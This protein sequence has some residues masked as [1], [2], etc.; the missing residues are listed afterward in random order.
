MP[1]ITINSKKT[2]HTVYGA[3]LRN[4]LLFNE[5]LPII[6]NSTLNQ[7]F[8]VAED[9][10]PTGLEKPIVQYFGVGLNGVIQDIGINNLYRTKYRQYQPRWGSALLSF[11]LVMRPIAEDLSIDERAF[12]RMRKLQ[13]FDGI[14]YA[15]YYLR[16]IDL[17][18][19]RSE[20]E[21]RTT[22]EGNVVTTSW[23]PTLN[24]LN[25]LA[26]EVNPNQVL[27]TGDD[28]LSVTRKIE[29]I[30]TPND[31]QELMNC[32]EIIYGDSAYANISE[33]IIASGI[34]RSVQGNF[35][36]VSLSYTEAIYAQVNAFVKTFLSAPNQLD[37]ATINVDVG[38]NEP[39]LIV[40]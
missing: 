31:I 33:L 34:E 8:S 28:Y 36:G 17:T 27:T 1:M 11:P 23:E 20:I 9:K 18:K 29:I 4:V 7:K 25:P 16:R 5:E 21:Y 3:L 13:E 32:S 6:P 15:C 30:F 38:A 37:G 2:T 14:V 40:S 26:L 12:Y 22:V 35:N 19:S 24:D 39:L 10:F